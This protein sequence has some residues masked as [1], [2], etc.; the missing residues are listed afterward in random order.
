MDIHAYADEHDVKR[1]SGK[2]VIFVSI[3]LFKCHIHTVQRFNVMLK[4]NGIPILMKQ[5][6][7]CEK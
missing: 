6:P 2:P 7:N 5:V 4:K 3:S 1:D